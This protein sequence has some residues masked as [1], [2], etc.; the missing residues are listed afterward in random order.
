MACQGL[1]IGDGG[2]FD[3]ICV[4][5]GILVINAVHLGGLDDGV[6]LQLH[7]A[8]GG[9]GVSGEIGV[10]CACGADDHAALFHVPE[11]TAADKGLAYL[12]H[13]DGRKDAGGIAELF[14]L[15]LHCQGIHH[16][17]QHAHIVSRGSFHA[18]CRT[19]KPPENVAA[20]YNKSH[21]DAVGKDSAK[22]LADKMHCVG[23][24]AKPLLAGKRLTAQLDKDSFVLDV[25]RH[26]DSP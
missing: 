5:G 19:G 15:V 3:C 16:R 6:A 1:V 11:G 18:P 10:A 4:L 24:D 22:F 23:V 26:K 13:G 14:Q 25:V 21:L 2:K 9:R 17:G 20:A 7:A 12:L 8:Q